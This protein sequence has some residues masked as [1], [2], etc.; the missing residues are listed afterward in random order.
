MDCGPVYWR[1]WHPSPGV[2]SVSHKYCYETQTSSGSLG[3]ASASGAS[4]RFGMVLG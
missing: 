3:I 4:A 1:A 2:L